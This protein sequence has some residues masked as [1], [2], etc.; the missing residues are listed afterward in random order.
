M[1]NS[2]KLLCLQGN[3]L[4]PGFEMTASVMIT[5]SFGV[6]RTT[7]PI[8]HFIENY[9]RAQFKVITASH[10]VSEGGGY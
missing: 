2:L 5:G 1:E 9:Y 6:Y 4:Q 7:K 8:Y 3:L 10:G